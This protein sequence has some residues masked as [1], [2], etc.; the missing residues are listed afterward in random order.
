MKV[1]F[2]QGTPVTLRRHGEP[3][4]IEVLCHKSAHA[5]AWN[6]SLDR[7]AEMPGIDPVKFNRASHDEA[8]G[9]VYAQVWRA[10]LEVDW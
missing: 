3:R 10:Y 7:I 1:L 8:W 9:F 5:L 2:D 4:A 6:Y